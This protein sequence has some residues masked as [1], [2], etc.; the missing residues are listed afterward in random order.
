[1]GKATAYDLCASLSSLIKL[2]EI[3]NKSGPMLGRL[4][5]HKVDKYI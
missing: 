1:M 4:R 2:F 3:M 5:K